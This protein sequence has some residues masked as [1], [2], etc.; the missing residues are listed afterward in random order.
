MPRLVTSFCL[1]VA[2]CTTWPQKSVSFVWR[3]EQ[4]GETSGMKFDPYRHP[5]EPEFVGTLNV[6]TLGGTVIGGLLWLVL[7]GLEKPKE[8]KDGK[9]K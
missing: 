5:K 6:I 1:S 2:T 9:G 3:D 7:V 8:D 4:S